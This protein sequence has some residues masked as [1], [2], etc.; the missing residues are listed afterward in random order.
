MKKIHF[1]LFVFSF[2]LILTFNLT[3][4]NEPYKNP[5]LLIEE[6]VNDLVS[7]MTLDEKIS[8]MMNIAVAIPRLGIPYYDWWNEGLHGVARTG[9]ATVF[10][11]AIGIAATFNDSLL[12]NVA[13]VISDEFRAKYN[14][15][16]KDKNEGFIGLTVWSPNINIFRDPRWGRGQET[17]GE[18][19]FLT[20]RMGVAFVK[21]MQGN[22]PF[23]LKTVSTPKHYLV[24]S[25]PEPLRHVFDAEINER[26]FLDTY[27]P[28]FEACVKEGKAYSIMS[29][30]NSFRG[31]PVSASK[32][33][34]TTLLRDTWGFKGY[35]VSDCDAVRDIYSTHKY[36][37]SMEEAA[38]LA[39]KAGLDLNCGT[40]FSH[41]KGAVEKGYLTEKD[42][43]VSVKRLMEARFR[44]GDFDPE[45]KVPYNKISPDINDSPEHRMLSIIA[46]QQSMVLL[47]NEKNLL[48]LKKDLTAIAVIGPNADNATVMYGNYNG[49][50]SKYVTPLQG[51][52]N[53]VSKQTKVYYAIGND[54]VEGM[55]TIENVPTE[56]LFSEDQHGLKG[57]YFT[58]PDISGN[59][60]EVRI[61]TLI[62]FNFEGKTIP[63]G[64]P[65]ENF[66]VRWTG[67]LLAPEDGK[68][69]LALTG[70]DGYRLF[71]DDSLLIDDW[72][73]HAPTTKSGT[74]EIQ[75]GSKHKIRIE[76]FQK[77]GG[78]SI[79]FSWHVFGKDRLKEA[80]D[81]AKK[82]D[83]IIYC[84]G[85]SPSLEGEEMD[86]PYEGFKGGDRTSIDLPAVQ[87]KML[88]KLQTTGKPIVFIIM[89]GSALSINWADKNLPAILEAWYPGQEGGTAIADI[90]FGDYNPAGR[91]PVTFYKSIDQLPTFEDY[92][93]KGR[94]YRYFEGEALYKFGYGLSYTSFRYSDLHMQKKMKTGDTLNVKVTVENNG[95]M[96]GDE[97]VQLYIKHLQTPVPVPNI[98]LEGFKR[99]H[100]K[101]GEKKVVEFNLTPYNMSVIDNSNKR[102]VISGEVEIFAGGEQPYT[103][104][105]KNKK[106][107]KT[108]VVLS[109]NDFMIE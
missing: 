55:A 76:Y 34:L 85:I 87:E 29:A 107:I 103:A 82:S 58:N 26:D 98:A 51:I 5:T 81:I 92:N 109:G 31:I 68:Y 90:L 105:L 46:A 19:P 10:P 74:I 94:T 79:K 20:S 104:G 59:P 88:K 62:D 69:Q 108:K 35:V 77:A 84:G 49:V 99:I 66:S 40:L 101:K 96:D 11:Q 100:L 1:L 33:L 39:V 44:L 75:K 73:E 64:F 43:D 27:A 38:A 16:I 42:I 53:K 32:Y 45:D 63:K 23:Y 47:K 52:K 15:Y 9:I 78:A 102:V 3:A 8:Q 17:Y 91:L 97:V 6:R 70:D 18:D 54:Y 61:D 65:L 83:V 37:S 13:T 25:G 56:Y 67:T 2:C 7:R 30:Y 50:P 36:A 4:Q 95:K 72:T 41:L 71:L 106:I 12:Y 24:H 14:A 28:A 22:D 86:V 48:P 60:K 93:M 80:L 21:G 57:E 89:N